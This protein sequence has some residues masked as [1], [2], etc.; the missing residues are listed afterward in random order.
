M[1]NL[2][3]IFLV[4]LFITCNKEEGSLFSDGCQGECDEWE[5]CMNISLSIFTAD[6]VCRPILRIH[7]GYW[8]GE[9][10]VV[11]H[12]GNSTLDTLT[13]LRLIC[14]L[15]DGRLS[16]PQNSADFQDENGVPPDDELNW[17][18]LEF[19]SPYSDTS[20]WNGSSGDI[21]INDSIYD[22]FVG[23]VVL[24]NGTGRIIQYNSS[25]YSRTLEFN[26]IYEFEGNSY[27]VSFSGTK[28]N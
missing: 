11:D 13:S 4:F 21:I 15:N 6:W 3:L 2:Y 9:Q 16:Y 24:Y 1:K 10:V 26:C 7:N 14:G 18:T 25:I 12:L 20:P 17:L 5:S 19:L 22:P 8:S 27:S 23:S 28:G